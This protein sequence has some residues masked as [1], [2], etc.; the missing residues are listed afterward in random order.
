MSVKNILTKKSIA[1]ICIL[2]IIWISL[3][4]L[5][6]QEAKIIKK[7]EEFYLK[8]SLDSRANELWVW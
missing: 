5:S 3:R 1:Y 8:N 7:Y 4:A 6:L 2:R